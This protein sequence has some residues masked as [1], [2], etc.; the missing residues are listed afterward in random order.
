MAINT[1]SLPVDIP[2]QRL[3]VSEDMYAPSI[4]APLPAKWH[5]SLA[6]FVFEPP[7]DPATVSNPD[8]I[9]TFIKLVATVSGFQPQG[10][11]ID[12]AALTGSFSTIVIQNFEKLT[13]HYF[14]CLSALVQVAVF[15][16]EGEFA[17]GQFPYLTDFEPKKREVVEL[18]SDTGEAL[19]QSSNSLNVRKGTTSTNSMEIVNIDRGGSFGITVDTPKGGG[20]VTASHQQEVGTRSVLGSEA[21]TLITTDA[22]REKRE[23]LSHTTNLSQLYQL[24]DSY[25]SGM[26]RAIF[27]LNARPHIIDSPFTFVNGPRR[28]EGIQE[29]F[30]VVRRPKAMRNFCVKA[31]LETAHLHESETTITEGETVF[32]RSQLTQSFSLHADGGRFSADE[33]AGAFA[34]RVPDGFKLDRSR[35]GGPFRIEWA[36]GAVSEGTMPAGVFW[37]LQ[38]NTDAD[39]RQEAIP[40]I[41]TF[42][43]HIDF[44]VRIHGIQN[45]GSPKDADMTWTFTVF[46]IS[47]DPISTPT[48][49]TEKHVDLFITAREVRGCTSFPP[50]PAPTTGTAVA[51]LTTRPPVS[52]PVEVSDTAVQQ[53]PFVL[54]EKPL[55]QEIKDLLAVA[56]TSGKEA[57]VAANAISRALHDELVASFRPKVRYVPGAIDFVHTAFAIRDLLNGVSEPPPNPEGA[58]SALA[59]RLPPTLRSR[60]EATMPGIA[61]A[62]LLRASEDRLRRR[63]GLSVREVRELKLQAA[64]VSVRRGAAARAAAPPPGEGSSDSVKSAGPATPPGGSRPSR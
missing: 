39:H 45:L 13:S 33:K 51:A 28:L 37:S 18:V 52:S 1:L 9:T 44:T 21:A 16:S 41:S 38:G 63:F 42:D 50:P 55:G 40:N 8:E 36:S 23:S 54:Y 3:A 59:G 15:P 10:E 11:E 7:P 17:I 56:K 22:S 29:F 5:S 6:V 57:A 12:T 14:P 60:V 62:E 64:G 58:A 27:F 34:I 43:D 47:V 24:L 31:V 4:D 2:W 25:H 20:G 46:I 32:E 35:G 30:G 49:R 19:T 48:T 26:N 53:A 61:P